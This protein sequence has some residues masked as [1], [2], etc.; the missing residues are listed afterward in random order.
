MSP[1]IESVDQAEALRLICPLPDGTV[2]GL[3]QVARRG[4]M[5]IAAELAQTI[6]EDTW[7][8]VRIRVVSPSAGPVD[9]NWFG[10]AKHGVFNEIHRAPSARDGGGELTRYNAD[11]MLIP[12]GIDAFRLRDAVAEYTAVFAPP[13]PAEFTASAHLGAVFSMARRL[14]HLG[15]IKPETLAGRAF[16]Y[17]EVLRDVAGE[18]HRDLLPLTGERRA[19]DNAP[20][21][22][23]EG[24]A[25]LRK[26]RAAMTTLAHSADEAA[27]P[28]FADVFREHAEDLDAIDNE[29]TADL[30]ADRAASGGAR[31]GAALRASAAPAPSRSAASTPLSISEPDRPQERGRR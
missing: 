9:A 24:L 10:F 6:R 3:R 11:V 5:V 8:G 27:H 29:I 15:S 20:V 25:A 7:S 28:G 2:V 22:V 14:D 18:I 19:A 12:E 26:L 30:A 1:W 4:D 21:E 17:A 16:E 13:P 31:V 23:A